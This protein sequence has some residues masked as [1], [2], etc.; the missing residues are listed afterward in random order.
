M[1]G[2]K[3]KEH[4]LMSQVYKNNSMAEKG[5]VSAVPFKIM[6]RTLKY[7]GVS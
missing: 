5:Y 1:A 3:I 6:E 7:L 2:Y 4:K